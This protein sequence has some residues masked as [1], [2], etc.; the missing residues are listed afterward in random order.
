MLAQ[1]PVPELAAAYE[2]CS[3]DYEV[4]MIDIETNG[5]RREANLLELAVYAPRGG[6]AFSTLVQLPRGVWVGPALFPDT[7]Q[8]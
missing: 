5:L 6:A 2:A 4:Y 1:H 8:A 3:G 7:L